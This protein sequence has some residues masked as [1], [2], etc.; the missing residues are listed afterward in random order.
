MNLCKLSQNA[1]Y[2]DGVFLLRPALVVISL[3]L[4][5]FL[6]PFAAS[7]KTISLES[8]EEQAVSNSFDLKLTDLDCKMA[9]ADTKIARADFFPTLNAGYN[10]Q[11]S[12]ALSNEISQQQV[13]VVGNTVLP[14]ATG[15]QH[16]YSFGTNYTMFDGGARVATYIATKRKQQAL[17]A[18]KTMLVRDIRLS[19]TQFYTEALIDYQTLQALEQM[20]QLHKR[21]FAVKQQLQ[22][23]RTISKVE[24]AEEALQMAEVDSRIQRVRE[25]LGEHLQDISLYTKE[26][27]NID[28]LQMTDI[29]ED[30][31]IKAPAKFDERQLPDMQRYNFEISSKRAELQAVSAQRLPQVSYYSNLIFYGGDK[32][33]WSRALTNTGPRQVYM[34]LSVS[35]PLFDGFK[36]QALRE[37]KRAEIERLSVERDKKLWELKAQHEKFV[38]GAKQYSVQLQTS[39]EILNTSTDKVSM[40]KKLNDHQLVDLGTLINEQISVIDHQL[41]LAKAKTLRLS[42]LRK[43]GIIQS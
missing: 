20:L 21:L 40:V 41:S 33:S 8:V 30:G 27:Y 18:S 23:V 43:A 42:L 5:L 9:K 4:M 19:V 3:V 1:I 16:V 24:L 35:M 7:A 25:S 17:A 6:E 13:A 32:N 28:D 11:Y 29:F 14:G 34:G 26:S 36:N 2:K 22:E 31:R 37:K 10:T 39:A 12:R 38:N 15:F